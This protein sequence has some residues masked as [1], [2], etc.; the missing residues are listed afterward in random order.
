M[1]L[2]QI[3][4]LFDVSQSFLRTPGRPPITTRGFFFRQRASQHGCCGTVNAKNYICI[5]DKAEFYKE[6]TA[7]YMLRQVSLSTESSNHRS[8]LFFA[9][10]ICIA[11]AICTQSL[12]SVCLSYELTEEGTLKRCSIDSIYSVYRDDLHSAN[13]KHVFL[14]YLKYASNRYTKCLLRPLHVLSDRH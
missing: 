8:L 14:C 13:S 7:T 9:S 1:S 3:T 6:S 2:R 4:A 5:R 10:C 12:V 11:L